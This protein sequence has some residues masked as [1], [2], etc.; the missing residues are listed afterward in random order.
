M[1]YTA[2]VIA[3]TAGSIAGWF[4]ARFHAAARAREIERRIN[5]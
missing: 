5:F 3:F 4:I 2:L 1:L